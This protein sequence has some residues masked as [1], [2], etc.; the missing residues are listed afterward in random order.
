MT[1]TMTPLFKKALLKA[2]EVRMQLGLN[3]FQPVNIYDVCAKLGVTVRF[4]DI[5]MEGFYTKQEDGTYPTILLSNQRPLPRRSYTCAHEF[6]H[7]VFGHGLKVDALFD[8]T[9]QTTSFDPDELLVDAFAGALLMPVAGIEA[10]FTKRKWAPKTASPLDFYTV[11]SSFGVGY[12]TLVNHC[13]A[14]QIISETTAMVLLKATPKKMF[15]SLFPAG[16][17]NAHFKIIDKHSKS[18]VVDLEVSNYIVLP[19]DVE[20]E[21]DHLRKQQATVF[22]TGYVAVRP[23]IVRA[24]APDGSMGVFVRIQNFQ[25]AGL[26]ENRHLENAIDEL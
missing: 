12:Q 11:C 15:A 17:E 19:A 22:G 2:D 1:S 7:H 25:Y 18:P 24:A 9:G 23:G 4:V 14:N 21:G 20:V 6:G 10:A 3:M 5:S 16:T 8:G 13:R 26:A